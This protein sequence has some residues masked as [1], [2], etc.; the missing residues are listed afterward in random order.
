MADFR[1]GR[2]SFG[3][4]IKGLMAIMFSLT[5]CYLAIKNLIGAEVFVPLAAIIVNSYFTKRGL[6]NE[7]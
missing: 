2:Y 1:A 5:T 7:S 3:F 6:G 4:S